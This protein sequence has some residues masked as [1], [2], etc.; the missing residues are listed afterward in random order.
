M[1][2]LA[3][4]HKLWAWL[5]R[6]PQLLVPSSARRWL[7]PVP[8]QPDGGVAAASAVPLE[9]GGLSVKSRTSRTSASGHLL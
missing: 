6:V 4:P 5:V 7:L 3:D 9:A 8:D 2:T 1:G